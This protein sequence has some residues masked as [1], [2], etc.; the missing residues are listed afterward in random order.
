MNS[1]LLLVTRDILIPDYVQVKNV[2]NL[3]LN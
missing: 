3:I 1:Q 2:N